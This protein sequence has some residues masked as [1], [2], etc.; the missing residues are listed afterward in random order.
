MVSVWWWRVVSR[1]RLQSYGG[2]RIEVTGNSLYR[3]RNAALLLIHCRCPLS[4]GSLRCLLEKR[5]LR[6]IGLLL[7]V[8]HGHRRHVCGLLSWIWR[9]SPLA[10]GRICVTIH[11]RRLTMGHWLILIDLHGISRLCGRLSLSL[12]LSRLRSSLFAQSLGLL[13]LMDARG[14]L[15]RRR[16]L[17][18]HWWYK[19]LSKFLLCNE[20]VQLRLLW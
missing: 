14:E 13:L 11:W 6:S 9:R 16:R 5:R 10:M 20:R 3:R 15:S 12:S 2:I 18:I 7:L 17:K 19:W 4:S 8:H 1:T